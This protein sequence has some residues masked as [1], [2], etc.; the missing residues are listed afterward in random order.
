M[1][2]MALMTPV[3]SQDYISKNRSLLLKNE[4]LNGQDWRKIIKW[5][6][7]YCLMQDSLFMSLPKTS[8]Y[9]SQ[10]ALRETLYKTWTGSSPIS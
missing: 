10:H 3:V 7:E 9:Q 6:V 5:F 8:S 1:S 4:K 2:E